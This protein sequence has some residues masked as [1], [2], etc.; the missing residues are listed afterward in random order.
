M[1]KF[2]KVVRCVGEKVITPDPHIKNRAAMVLLHKQLVVLSPYHGYRGWLRFRHELLT[3]WLEERGV[4]SCHYCGKGDLLIDSQSA[5]DVA[6]LDHVKALALGGER[7]NPDNLVVACAR[8]NQKKGHKPLEEFQ[9]HLD[10][11]V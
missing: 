2:S 5:R 9:K 1:S 6:T 4:L 7:F 3:K 11:S 10:E 8:C